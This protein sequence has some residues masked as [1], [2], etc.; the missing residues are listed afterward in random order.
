V[1]NNSTPVKKKFTLT[2][3]CTILVAG[4][5][6]TGLPS[7]AEAKK[8]R[9]YSSYN[10]SKGKKGRNKTRSIAGKKK[11]SAR[12]SA[13][14]KKQ[15]EDNPSCMRATNYF[16]PKAEDYSCNANQKISIPLGGGSTKICPM[17]RKES[18]MQGSIQVKSGDDTYLYRYTGKSEKIP[19][20]CKTTTGAA[21]VCLIPY[22]HIA[23]DPRYYRMG[24]IVEV[25]SLKDVEVPHPS[26]SGTMKHP[27][28]FI[29]AD[30]GGKIKGPNRF[31]FFIGTTTWSSRKNPFGPHG[32]KMTDASACNRSF[33]R[34]ERGSQLAQN[35]KDEIYANIEEPPVRT[36]AASPQP[37]PLAGL[38]PVDGGVR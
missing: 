26:G 33:S 29:V 11:N 31:D 21:G 36:Y 4:F 28:Y 5:T 35:I 23:A 17:A 27:G 8:S 6:I 34:V 18:V 24:D 1:K 2:I 9:S 20:D 30:T 22:I 10:S 19:S 3:F 32:E 14:Y 16:L 25:P 38:S 15:R 12:K 37:T 7:T 13:S